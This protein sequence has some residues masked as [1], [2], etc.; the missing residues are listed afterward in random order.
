MR[1]AAL[2]ALLMSAWGCARA[3]SAPAEGSSAGSKRPPVV[4]PAVM[5]REA[6]ALRD[7][8]ADPGASD[9][10][11]HEGAA[12][13]FQNTQSQTPVVRPDWQPVDREN[14]DGRVGTIDGMIA[15]GQERFAQY[16]DRFTG[17]VLVTDRDKIGPFVTAKAAL[18]PF[19]VAVLEPR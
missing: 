5:Q 9:V 1:F 3:Q 18:T 15:T 2:V 4:D 10:R 7:S 19:P 6:D 13:L 12:A 16:R 17:A 14:V 11:L 8:V